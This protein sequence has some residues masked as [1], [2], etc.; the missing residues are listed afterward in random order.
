[1]ENLPEQGA[2][3]GGWTRQHLFQ[4]KGAMSK[5]NNKNLCPRQVQRDWGKHT[6]DVESM[7]ARDGDR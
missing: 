4:K 2:A 7:A 5:H 3:N 6:T 1:M